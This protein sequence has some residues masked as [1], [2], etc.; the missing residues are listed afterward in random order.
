MEEKMKKLFVGA[1]ITL[2]LGLVPASQA[3]ASLSLTETFLGTKTDG[4]YFDVYEGYTATFGFNLTS[5]G[6]QA[7]LFD[8]DGNVADDRDYPTTDVDTFVPS[9]Q[10]ITAATLSFRFSS[11]DLAPE[12]VQVKTS[13]S[14]GGGILLEENFWLFSIFGFGNSTADVNLDLED[15]LS[16]LQDGIFLTL[17]IA[18]E[19]GCFFPNDFRIDQAS[20]EVTAVPIPGAFWLLGSGLIGIVGLRKKS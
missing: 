13:L 10:S 7:L 14:N 8:G 12:T 16:Y 18:P 4:D 9:N 19:S 6:D 3:L 11:Q 17:V 15:Y 2:L 5:L 20:L 1:T